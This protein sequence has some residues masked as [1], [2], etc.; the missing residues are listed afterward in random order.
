MPELPGSRLVIAGW[1]SSLLTHPAG[2]PDGLG[3][4]VTQACFASFHG[5]AYPLHLRG[6]IALIGSGCLIPLALSDDS[7]G[8][9]DFH[10]NSLADD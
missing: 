6:L 1:A 10:R 5:R 2:Q 7:P 8:A 3:R 9:N 4:S